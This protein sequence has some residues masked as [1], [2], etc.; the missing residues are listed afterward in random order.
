M[1]LFELLKLMSESQAQTYSA[2]EVKQM[3]DAQREAILLLITILKFSSLG[4]ILYSCWN[5]IHK[6]W[7]KEKIKKLEENQKKS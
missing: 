7:L 3:L 4:V 5:E 2:V 6:L 1:E